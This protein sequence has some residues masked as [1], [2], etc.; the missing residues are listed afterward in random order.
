MWAEVRE[1]LN[2]QFRASSV[3]AEKIED[4]ETRVAN[5][6]LAPVAG[7]QALLAAFS[8]DTQL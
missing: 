4:L 1:A 7:A 2:E 5:G 3:V 6:S 8:G